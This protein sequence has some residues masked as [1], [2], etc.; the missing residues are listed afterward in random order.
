MHNNICQLNHYLLWYKYSE[1]T[2][3]PGS[4]PVGDGLY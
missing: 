4:T 2:V 1:D 3:S